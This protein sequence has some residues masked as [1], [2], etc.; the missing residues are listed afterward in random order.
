MSGLIWP[1]AERHLARTLIIRR[2][3]EHFHALS[4]TC[5]HSEVC[6]LS[7]NPDRRQVICPCH[8][9]VFDLYGNVVSGPPPRPL[10]HREVVVRDGQLY[11]RRTS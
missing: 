8:Q 6:L 9:G 11:V 10:E 3:K 5:T 7:W 4:A 2:D 1:E